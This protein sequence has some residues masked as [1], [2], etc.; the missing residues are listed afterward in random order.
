MPLEFRVSGA[1]TR[2]EHKA[3]TLRLT[4]AN[5]LVV[6]ASVYHFF[7]AVKTVGTDVVS[8]VG[9]AC[10]LVHGQGRTGQGIV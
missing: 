10:R 4:K 8:T 7:T 1:S 5:D 9:L 2:G 6:A 3:C